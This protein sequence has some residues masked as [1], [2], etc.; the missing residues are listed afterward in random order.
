MCKDTVERLLREIYGEVRRNYR[1]KIGTLPEDYHGQRI[2]GQLSTIYSALQ[3]CRGSTEFVRARNIEADYFVPEPGFIV[4][5]D[6]SQHFTEPRKI[7]LSYYPSDLK[8]G[9][10]REA[11]VKHCDEIHAHDDEPPF[12]DEQRAWYDTLRDFLPEIK[13]FL[14]TVRLYAKEREWCRMD[15]S[16]DEDR[17]K[18]KN[19]ISE[20]QRNTDIEAIADP[21]PKFGRVIIAG[22]W[23][24]NITRAKA[25]MEDIIQQWPTQ[26]R[27]AFFV[28]P[29]AFLRFP[30]PEHFPAPS[31]NLHPPEETLTLLRNTA[32]EYCDRLLDEKLRSDLA[33]HADYLTIGIDSADETKSNGYQVEFVAVVD[34]KTNQYFWT[35]KSYPDSPQQNRLIRVSDLSSHFIQ[36][37]IGKVMVLGCHDLKMF[38]NR[39]R[40]AANTVPG[41]TW[42]KTVH[43]EIDQLITQEKP[44]IILQHPHTTDRYRS[45]YTEWNELA[46][47][48]PPEVTYI[49]SGLYY[50]YGEKCR[51]SLADVRKYTRRGPSIDFVVHVEGTH[52]S[53]ATIAENLPGKTKPEE[54]EKRIPAK[55][56]K[57][58][59]PEF[60]NLIETYRE[61]AGPLFRKGGTSSKENYV[62]KIK[63]MPPGVMY[64]FCHFPQEKKFSVELAV[65]KARAPQ[66]ET[67]IRDL[68]QKPFERLPDSTFWEQKTKDGTWL[69]LQFFYPDDA[70]AFTVVQG[71]FDLIDQSYPEIAQY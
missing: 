65:N 62:V 20:R 55:A 25:L 2:Y 29:G 24:G 38:S 10:S 32:Q 64:Y 48:C 41:S 54:P 15:P 13:G 16:K 6:E 47:R 4:E 51:S 39:G 22:P 57:Q 70:P 26:D 58:Y 60:E 43:Q 61:M 59:H 71:M 44:V 31:D 69:R 30:W 8:T 21:N 1:I 42:R 35:G 68:K 19:I 5:F 40:A 67:M 12:R 50:Y 27:V 36:I 3:N 14:P 18:M 52:Q 37:P 46:S 17:E 28:T 7:A 34:L 23:E 63:E 53:T 49:S 66:F 9:F 11:W 33:R 45:W 56:Q